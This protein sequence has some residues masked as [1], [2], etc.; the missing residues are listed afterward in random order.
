M[1]KVV[2]AGNSSTSVMEPTLSGAYVERTYDC[3]LWRCEGCGRVWDK[4]WYAES[5]EGR[6]HVNSFDQG[7]YG[8]TGMVNGVPQGNLRWYTRAM[9]RR[10][11][12]PVG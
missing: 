4:R 5:C 2:P 12:V 9:I 11:P 1:S 8:C 3:T 7:P 6:G 10:D